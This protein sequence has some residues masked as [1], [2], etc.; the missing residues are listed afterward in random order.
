VFVRPDRAKPFEVSIRPTLRFDVDVTGATSSGK[1]MFALKK[2]SGSNAGA[3]LTVGGSDGANCKRQA[4][5][6]SSGH[7][8]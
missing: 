4:A 3:S 8:P 7:L 5:Q 6:C 2:R 1:F